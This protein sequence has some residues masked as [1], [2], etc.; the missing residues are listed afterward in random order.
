MIQYP[1][2]TESV[3]FKKECT[4]TVFTKATL[5]SSTV[6]LSPIKLESASRIEDVKGHAYIDFANRYVGNGSL[7]SVATQEHIL[8]A[9]FPE[10]CIS[11]GL[12]GPMDDLEAVSI[13]NLIRSANYSGYGSSFCF[14]SPH[15]TY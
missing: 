8:C 3:I 6:P 15:V 13:E 5:L 7:S 4:P 11:L 1:H 14:D 9:I 2:L 10:A 12:F